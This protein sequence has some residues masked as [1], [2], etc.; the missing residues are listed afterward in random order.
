MPSYAQGRGIVL[1]DPTGL[2]GKTAPPTTGNTAQRQAWVSIMLESAYEAPPS[3]PS[4]PIVEP[5]AV[6]YRHSGGEIQLPT[7]TNR[8]AFFARSSRH[9][10]PAE[11]S[12]RA[13]RRT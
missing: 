10:S 12:M 1:R 2:R 11:L 4:R 8:G 7:S 13:E 3:V 6:H 5:N 9:L